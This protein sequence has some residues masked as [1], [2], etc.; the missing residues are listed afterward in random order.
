MTRYQLSTINISL[1]LKLI[2][3]FDITEI[4]QK[5]VCSLCVLTFYHWFGIMVIFTWINM[6]NIKTKPRRQ[7]WYG[8]ALQE[9]LSFP[10][11]VL[12]YFS[13]LSVLF[14]PHMKDQICDSPKEVF[15]RALLDSSK[16]GLTVEFGNTLQETCGISVILLWNTGVH[17]PKYK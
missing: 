5:Q 10:S 7:I 14:V 9:H 17:S 8:E 3:K 13:S 4:V 6:C 1:I 16:W 15:E 12:K 2:R 11:W